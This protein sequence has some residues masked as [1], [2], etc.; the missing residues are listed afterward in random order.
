MDL[1]AWVK[2]LVEKY[3]VDC[4]LNY[5]AWKRQISQFWFYYFFLISW[6]HSYC[7]SSV[8]AL[9]W[10]LN[11]SIGMGKTIVEFFSAAIELSVCKYLKYRSM[12]FDFERNWPKL[13]CSW[14]WCY[15]ISSLFQI[16]WGVH[17]TFGSDNLKVWGLLYNRLHSK[18]KTVQ[19]KA[20]LAMKLK[21]F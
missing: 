7:G 11:I 3:S 1:L 20:G 12:N 15:R 16:T 17:L 8:I 5:I 19:C 14:G 4:M 9:P 10:P 6:A 21:T 13:K 18:T 2:C